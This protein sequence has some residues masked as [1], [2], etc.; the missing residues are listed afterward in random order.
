MRDEDVFVLGDDI[1]EE[2]DSDDEDTGNMRARLD[3]APT[4]TTMSITP[5]TSSSGSSCTRV[6]GSYNSSGTS[7]GKPRDPHIPKY[8]IKPDDTLVG[9]ALRF[10]IDG[11]VLCRLNGLPPSTLRTTPHLLHTRT[12]LTFPLSARAMEPQS[13]SAI[14]AE[15]ERKVKHARE[16]AETRLQALTKEVDRHVAQA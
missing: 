9:I 5:S 4:D 8:Y 2:F 1:D 16:H 15:E 6:D 10:G 13:P 3:S 12:F 7:E 11:R 14:A